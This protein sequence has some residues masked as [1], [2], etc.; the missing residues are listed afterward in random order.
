MIVQVSEL[1]VAMR[2]L[3]EIWIDVDRVLA[4]GANIDACDVSSSP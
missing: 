4:P 3:A 1:Q 2:S